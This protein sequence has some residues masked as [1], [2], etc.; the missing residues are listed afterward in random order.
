MYKPVHFRRFGEIISILPE[1][2]L[3][4]KKFNLL[5]A[6]ALPVIFLFPACESAHDHEDDT[7]I[8]MDSVRVQ[9]EAMEAAYAAASNAKDVEGVAAY[10][11]ADAQSLAANEPTWVGID[12]IKAGIKKDMEEDSSGTTISFTTTGLWAAGNYVIETGTSTNKDSTGAVKASGKYMSLF[13]LRD[14]KYVC[15]RDIWNSDSKSE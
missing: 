7:A 5:W 14:G 3:L 10:Y 12:A 2:P 11:A 1:N 9:I 8:N 13:E 6:L 15:I 4:M